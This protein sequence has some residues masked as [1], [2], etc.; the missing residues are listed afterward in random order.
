MAEYKKDKKDKKSSRRRRH[1]KRM[2]GAE[3]ASRGEYSRYGDLNPKDV[4]TG[5]ATYG[6]N[7]YQDDPGTSTRDY[8]VAVKRGHSKSY[9]RFQNKLYEVTNTS[10]TTYEKMAV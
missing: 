9:F 6:V 1:L 10:G 4:H 7:T 8:S 5:P 3:I 2:A